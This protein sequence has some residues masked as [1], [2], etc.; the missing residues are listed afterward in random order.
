MSHSSA[1]AEYRGVANAVAEIAWLQNI[2]LEMC[3]LLQKALVVYCDNVSTIY[4]SNNP[5]QNQ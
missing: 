3:C 2:F 4:L 1:E 5:V